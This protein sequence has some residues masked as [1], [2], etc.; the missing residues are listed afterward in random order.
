[1]CEYCNKIDKKLILDDEAL[2]YIDFD[3]AYPALAIEY[4]SEE[5]DIDSMCIT[6]FKINIDYC[7]MCGRK[8]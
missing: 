5:K 2:V 7:P 6:Q 1:V 8:L 4:T 3:R